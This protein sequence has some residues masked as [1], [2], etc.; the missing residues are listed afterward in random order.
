MSTT[1]RKL[2]AT[3]TGSGTPNPLTVLEA[4]FEALEE[5]LDTFLVF[6]AGAA[7]AINAP[8]Y[9]DTADTTL[10]GTLSIAD[11]AAS[12]VGVGTAF[13]TE[14][15]SGDFITIS[16]TVFQIDSVSSTTAASAT[17]VNGTGGL[18]TSASVTRWAVKNAQRLDTGA[19]TKMAIGLVVEGV[20]SGGLARI[21]SYGMMEGFSSLTPGAPYMLS[22]SA[23][24][25][26]LTSAEN[27]V[28]NYQILGFALSATEFFIQINS[29]ANIGMLSGATDRA[30]DDVSAESSPKTYTVAT[31]GDVFAFEATTGTLD[32]DFTTIYD[33]TGISASLATK[34]IVHLR[35]TK[36]ISA[37]AR[38]HTVTLKIG[39]VTIFSAA[40]P[41]QTGADST[42]VSMLV[43][44]NPNSS[45]WTAATL[46]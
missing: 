15:Q 14:L 24:T 18:L 39:G 4:L 35:A 21:Q 44:Y 23:G 20:A 46:T 26:V 42:D 13:T 28:G 37:G 31:P 2:R 30:Q 45:L 33:L 29:P 7:L 3:L 34:V 8:V 40:T 6:R 22:S 17:Q 10:T 36:G 43:N 32:L 11:G 27:P 1:L 5:D 25:M 41:S 16:N 38:S 12:I 19:Y 9:L